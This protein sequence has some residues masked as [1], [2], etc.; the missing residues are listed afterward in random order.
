MI[1]RF[2]DTAEARTLFVRQLFEQ[3]V[4][5]RVGARLRC[6]AAAC[7]VWENMCR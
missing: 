1:T 5:P 6:A 4:S 3:L 7:Y 2:R